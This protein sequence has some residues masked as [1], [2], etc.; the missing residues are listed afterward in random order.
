MRPVPVNRSALRATGPRQLVALPRLP[1]LPWRWQALLLLAGSGVGW[2]LLAEGGAWAGHILLSQSQAP[3]L[4]D[5][6][7]RAAG[8]YLVLAGARALLATAGLTQS[9]MAPFLVRVHATLVQCAG[10]CV[11]AP[12]VLS[13]GLIIALGWVALAT[14]GDTERARRWLN[15]GQRALYLGFLAE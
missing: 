11:L 1:R 2:V 15:A 5:L 4:L 10:F 12:L 7:A 13:G 8:L 6:L 14:T 3:W 9:D